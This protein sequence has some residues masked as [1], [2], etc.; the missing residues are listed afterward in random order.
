V[1]IRRPIPDIAAAVERVI[2]APPTALDGRPVVEVQQPA[3]DILVLHLEGDARVVVRPSGTEPKLKT[4]LQVV[5]DDFDDY[6]TA[7]AAAAD[8]I[9][10][11]RRD[12]VGVLGLGD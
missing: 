12:L 7:K 5:V 10:S 6:D 9:E 1:S 11:L 4:Y 2:A 3:D 8:D